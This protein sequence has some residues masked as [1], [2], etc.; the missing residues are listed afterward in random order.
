MLDCS[1]ASVC[2]SRLADD[3][4]LAELIELFVAELPGRIADMQAAFDSENWTTL[5]TLAH[6]LKGAG[7][8]HGFDALTPAA[9]AVEHAA[10]TGLPRERVAA[11]LEQL[12]AVC[13][14]VRSGKPE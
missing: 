3:A 9:F 8:S 2:H 10:R 14:S 4:D 1:P 12:R 13:A 6:Q 7:G 11:A 5:G